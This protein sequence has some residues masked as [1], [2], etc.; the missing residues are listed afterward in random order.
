MQ[1][2]IGQSALLTATV[3]EY[4]N[5]D[6]VRLALVNVGGKTLWIPASALEPKVTVNT[7]SA[8][9]GSPVKGIVKPKPEG[10]TRTK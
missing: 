6:D 7:E 9:S 2:E 1:I 4:K 3:M 8:T 5:E 10:S